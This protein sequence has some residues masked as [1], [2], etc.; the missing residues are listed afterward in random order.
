MKK[1]LSRK[2][3][4]HPSILDEKGTLRRRFYE[5]EKKTKIMKPVLAGKVFEVGLNILEETADNALN[6]K[7]GV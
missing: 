6:S 4:F 3:E 5:L 2:P 1:N 7:S